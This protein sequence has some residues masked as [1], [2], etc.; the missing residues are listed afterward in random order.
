[1]ETLT[2]LELSLKIIINSTT[3][4]IVSHDWLRIYSN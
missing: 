1:M 3:T 4:E 2:E